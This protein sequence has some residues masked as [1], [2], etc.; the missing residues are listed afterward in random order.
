[1]KLHIALLS[2]MLRE[3]I[4]EIQFLTTFLKCVANQSRI[5]YILAAHIMNAISLVFQKLHVNFHRLYKNGSCPSRWK[6]YWQV[7]QMRD[8]M[9]SATSFYVIVSE[10]WKILKRHCYAWL[11][12]E[13]M[14]NNRLVYGEKVYWHFF[15]ILNCV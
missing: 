9:F 10:A 11:L 8:F 15:T 3:E 14:K 2:E 12:V 6:Q 1:M 5:T 4:L 13:A 7:D